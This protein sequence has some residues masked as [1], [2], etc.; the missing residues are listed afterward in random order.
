MIR[1]D[2]SARLNVRRQDF[3]ILLSIYAASSGKATKG[4][5]CCL[6]VGDDRVDGRLAAQ[7]P[8]NVLW[9]AAAARLWSGRDAVLLLEHMVLQLPHPPGGYLSSDTGRGDWR[10]D[11]AD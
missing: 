5:V 4:G 8:A 9:H 10:G 7:T 3:F 1:D 6:F 11:W 2:E